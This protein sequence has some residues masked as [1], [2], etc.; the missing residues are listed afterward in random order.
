MPSYGGGNVAG[1]AWLPPILTISSA[2]RASAYGGE[3]MGGVN[4]DFAGP[5]AA[6]GLGLSISTVTPMSMY[7]LRRLKS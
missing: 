5:T 7:L 2:L 3:V 4:Q 6:Y 1:K